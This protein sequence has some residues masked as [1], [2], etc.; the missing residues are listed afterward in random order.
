MVKYAPI[1]SYIKSYNTKMSLVKP[2]EEQASSEISYD[3]T[4]DIL[5]PLRKFCKLLIL[6]GKLWKYLWYN[7]D[8][9]EVV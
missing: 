4:C 2:I 5:V 6:S 9:S 3:N 1:L 8:I 7:A